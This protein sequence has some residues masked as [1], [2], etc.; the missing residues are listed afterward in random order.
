MGRFQIGEQ[1]RLVTNPLDEQL[2]EYINLGVKTV[3]DVKD[4]NHM[5]GTSG[6]WVK[7]AGWH[8]DWIDSS[9]FEAIQPK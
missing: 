2:G 4:V 5:E 6:Q 1:V 9:Y 8:I 7:I 3:I